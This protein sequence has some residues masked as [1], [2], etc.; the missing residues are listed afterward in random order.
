VAIQPAESQPEHSS[1][2]STPPS[3]MATIAVDDLGVTVHADLRITGVVTEVRDMFSA[4]APQ[5]QPA[6]LEK[7]IVTGATI[8][9]TAAEISTTDAARM[10]LER[11]ADALMTAHD[12]LVERHE[13]QAKQL[14]EQV[15]AA[16]KALRMQLG[17]SRTQEEEL[18]KQ[19]R[20][21]QS[22]VVKAAKALD[23]SRTELEQHANTAISK[24]V[25]AQTK[26]K[27]DVVKATDT[28]L[29]KLLDA[30]DPTSA[31]ALITTV[32][33]TAAADMRANT[34]KSVADLTRDLGKAFGE[35]SP[36]VDRIAKIVRTGAEAE[37]KR[38]E[39]QVDRLRAD[40]LQSRTRQ[41]HSPHLIGE[42]YEDQLL[43]LLGEG[44]AV[45]GWTADRTG[46][47]I[48][49]SVDSKKGD[50]LLSDETNQPV[51]AIE[52]RARK[53]VSSRAFY[54]ALRATATNRGVKIVVYFARS[55]DDLPS[56]LG[57]FSHGLVPFHYKKL[58]DGVHALA[59]VIDPMSPLAV[60]RLAMM[61]WLIQ[62]INAQR[63]ERTTQTDA[64]A[65]IATA[66]PWVQQITSR[67]S[68]FTA[69]KSGLTKADGEIT[70]VRGKVSELQETLTEELSV[71]EKIL[72]D[73]SPSA[74]DEAA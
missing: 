39:E 72:W 36:L 15:D 59:S 32:M 52:A 14:A 68:A 33:N 29:R 54:E 62:R 70:K 73:D 64:V 31:P 23:L 38:V 67:L 2:P 13:L 60:E 61:L 46:T 41:Q 63:P 56:G 58:A 37:I 16:V 28:A 45:H 7:I 22:E 49:A 69:I 25:E 30:E 1:P 55:T 19:I 26:A 74:K 50:H 12:R 24:M 35:D 51:A 9:A 34:T 8:V 65:R 11:S 3:R 44:A 42:S 21:G 40:L 66:L 47:D 48:G 4:T 18:R 43:E 57:E 10:K 5:E 6:L 20:E 53:N 71:L 27:D 17:D